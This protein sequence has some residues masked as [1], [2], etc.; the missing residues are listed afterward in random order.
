MFGIT[1][2]IIQFILYD[3]SNT[4]IF[5]QRRRLESKVFNFFFQNLVLKIILMRIVHNF[6]ILLTLYCA[7]Y[8]IFC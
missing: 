5:P 4:E 3:T 8:F 7:N 6:I 1:I 2:Y